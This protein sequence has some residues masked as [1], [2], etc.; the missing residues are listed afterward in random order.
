MTHIVEKSPKRSRQFSS[1]KSIEEH[2]LT[3]ASLIAPVWP[4]K[5]AIACNPLL[6]LEDQTFWEAVALSQDI[7][8]KKPTPQSQ[9]INLELIKWLEVYLDQGQSSIKMPSKHLGFY[10]CWKEL[11][12]FDSRIVKTKN[13]LRELNKLPAAPSLAVEY[14]LNRLKIPKSKIDSYLQEELSQL[15]GWAGYIRWHSEWNQNCCQKI[16]LTDL[17][18][19]RLAITW[20][21]FER[22]DF[23]RGDSSLPMKN[24][25]WD[26]L[27][28]ESREDQFA[29]SLINEVAK[30]IQKE[31]PFKTAEAQCVF[32]IDVRSEPFR[33]QLEKT[34]SYETFGF[35][36]FFGIP[37]EVSQ[38]GSIAYPS[39]PVLL[40]PAW[41]I[42]SNTKNA[43]S[44]PA[45]FLKSMKALGEQIYKEL[46]YN[47]GTAF[48][49]VET[50]GFWSGLWMGLK[51]W[52]PGFALFLKN[53]FLNSTTS[54]LNFQSMPLNDQ[55]H[56]AHSALKMMGLIK[57]FAPLILFCG[58]RSTSQ[59]N[60]FASSLDCGACGGNHGGINARLLAAIL[61]RKEVRQELLNRGIEIPKNTLFIGAEHNTTTD[62]VT[63]F[64]E[65]IHRQSDLKKLKCDLQ[66]AA[67]A[68]RVNRHHLLNPT[69][70][71]LTHSEGICRS[72]DWS[73]VRPEWGLAKNSAFIVAPRKLTEDTD[74]QGR[75]FLHSYDWEIDTEGTDLE[76]ILTAP[77]VVAEWINTQYFFSTFDPISY[78]S[79]SKITQNVVGKIGV[80]QGNG[81]D[82]MH[83]LPMQSLYLSEDAA[84]HEPMRLLTLIYAP[85]ER[86]DQI[87]QRQPLLQ[88]LF[89][90]GWVK[91]AAI[92]PKTR[93][94]YKLDPKGGWKKIEEGKE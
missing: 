23:D 54:S 52:S 12:A 42:S 1:S 37:I 57:N 11:A 31:R 84:Y 53:I 3:A 32:C 85:T 92:D 65:E 19:V 30:S 86:I 9:S 28:I 13:H 17:I 63:L 45:H 87:I 89:N 59:N 90:N 18:A 83:G 40:K 49:L 27:D 26:R 10:R 39:C 68:N 69:P 25:R 47:F 7:L 6:N 80:M 20:I 72:S 14:L 15:P 48:P 93:M 88:K 36:G 2:I 4:L 5:T 29:T 56:Y 70:S 55:I 78:G 94:K 51:A 64:E 34:G 79:G 8:L 43:S 58:H 82:L 16:D 21:L 35:A 22:A 71:P 33:R 60:P 91:V 74:L 24:R 81:S 67:N 66:K 61:N 73:E 77:M 44:L 50:V 75:C 76:T 62:E 38:D 46:K 41:K